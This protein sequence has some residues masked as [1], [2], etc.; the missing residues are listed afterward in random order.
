MA[1]TNW[2]KNVNW[3]VNGEDADD[4]TLNRP[5]K[6]VVEILNGR[7]N[8]TTTISSNTTSVNVSVD[9]SKIDTDKLIIIVNGAFQDTNCYSKSV[10]SSSISFTFKSTLQKNT[11]VKIMSI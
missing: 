9:T 6:E 8:Y 7:L 5:L 3:L 4:V 2:T 11:V 1:A 10:S